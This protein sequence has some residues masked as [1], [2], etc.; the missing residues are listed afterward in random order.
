MVAS[1]LLAM[2][3][4]VPGVGDVTLDCASPRLWKFEM[5]SGAVSDGISTVKVKFDAPPARVERLGGDGVW[6]QVAQTL[7]VD[8]SVV[9]DSP[10]RPQSAAIFR[11]GRWESLGQPL[12]PMK[13]EGEADGGV[14]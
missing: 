12:V 5:S 6:R 11:Y 14:V 8:G 3:V 10:V 2:S 9:L 13:P 4:V 7:H 1:I